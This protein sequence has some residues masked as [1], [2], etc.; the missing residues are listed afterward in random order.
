MLK[1]IRHTLAAAA[2]LTGAGAIVALG[3]TAASA[4]TARPAVKSYT[5]TAVTKLSDRPDSG[6]HG[7]WA[8]DTFT[9]TAHLTLVSQVASSYCAGKTSHCYHWT[10]SVSDAGSF[11]TI[12]GDVSP[13]NGDLNGGS[14]A[15]IGTVVK[16][17][18]SGSYKYDFYAS[19]KTA[20]ASLVPTSENDQGNVPGG[21]STTGAWVEQ[22]FGTTAQ[23]FTGGAASNELGTTGS[24]TYGAAFGADSACPAVASQW[25]D[26]SPDWGTN[27]GDGNILA[28]SA[29]DC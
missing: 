25:T 12:P 20:K 13:G 18:M 21:R 15:A 7:N 8:D 16:G 14:P 22:F 24:W 27:A 29:A 10:G 3:L 19:W 23:F 28:P 1:R 9:R 2:A 26:A 4:A 5:V 11:A 6:V 17:S